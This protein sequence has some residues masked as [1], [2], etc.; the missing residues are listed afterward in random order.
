LTPVL[1]Y[2]ADLPTPRPGATP[3]PTRPPIPSVLAGKI[4]FISDMDGAEH[5][6]ALDPDTGRIGRLTDRWP[7]ESAAAREPLSSDGI[8][9][10]FSQRDGNGRVQVWYHDAQYNVVKQLTWFGA[11]AAWSPAWSPTG[12]RVAL[13]SNESGNDEIWLATVGERDVRQIT[14]NTWEWDQHPSWSPDGRTLVFMSNR[15]GQRRL[16]LMDAE[17]NA[18]RL[19]TDDRFAAWDPVWVK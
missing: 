6:Y 10:A 4:L 13:V 19:L 16:W 8:L 1:V 14:H 17:G 7:Y 11:G 9:R 18:P 2:L 15:T 5:A 12:N 3:T